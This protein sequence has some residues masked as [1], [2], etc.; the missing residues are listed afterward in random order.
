METDTFES[1][2]RQALA[3]GAGKVPADAIA[4]LEHRHFRLPVARRTRIASAGLAGVAAAAAVIAIAVAQPARQ[5]A[6]ATGGGSTGGG[7]GKV[8]L[9]DWA[10]SRAPDGTVDVTIRQLSD[11]AGLQARLRADGVPASVSTGGNPACRAYPVNAARIFQFRRAQPARGTTTIVIHT[12]ALPSGAGLMIGG[13][14]PG[15]VMMQ[16][17]RVSQGCTGG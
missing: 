2:L 5:P 6:G 7:T 1:D 9:A 17:V 4:R 8:Q 15:T 12:P 11:P 10:V 3:R 14:Y 16:V 13:Q